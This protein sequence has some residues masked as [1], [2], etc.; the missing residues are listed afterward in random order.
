M[1]QGCTYLHNNVCICSN[2]LFG[3]EILQNI[4]DISNIAGWKQR[5]L[6]KLYIAIMCH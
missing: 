1:A 6:G 4:L 5:E 3:R 2:V